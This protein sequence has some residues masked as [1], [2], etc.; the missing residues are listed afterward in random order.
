MITSYYLCD[1]V[2]VCHALPNLVQCIVHWGKRERIIRQEVFTFFVVGDAAV[3]MY[4]IHRDNHSQSSS[5]DKEIEKWVARSYF[6]N[7]SSV[8]ALLKLALSSFISFFIFKCWFCIN[9]AKRLVKKL[10]PLFHPT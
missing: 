4:I 7:S 10:A 6:G 1:D 3:A 9:Y 2:V 5:F 8:K